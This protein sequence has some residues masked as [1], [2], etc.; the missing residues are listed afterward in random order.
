MR[1]AAKTAGKDPVEFRLSHLDQTDDN[2]ARVAGVLQLAA[3]KAGWDGKQ[4][5]GKGRGVAVHK[6]FD[7][8]V[9]Q[10]TDVS[11]NAEGAVSI[12]KVVCT[13]DFGVAVNPDVIRA[14]MEGAIGFGMG[15]VMRNEITLKDRQFPSTRASAYHRHAGGGSAYRG[16]RQSALWRG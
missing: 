4:V 8:Y 1:M 6:S 2:Q 5:P 11:V 3:D 14:Q 10:V 7:T 12:D 15:A 13:V 16:F 9:A